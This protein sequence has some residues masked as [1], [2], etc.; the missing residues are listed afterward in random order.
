MIDVRVLGY[1]VVEATRVD[2]WRRYAEDVL[3]MRALDARDGERPDDLRARVRI[4]VKAGGPAEKRGAYRIGLHR[5][6]TPAGQGAHGGHACALHQN[7]LTKRL[8]WRSVRD[9]SRQEVRLLIIGRTQCGSRW[10][11]PL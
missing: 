4:T 2:A 1:V 10:S 6:A 11:L 3:G 9:R 7:V 8:V 5:P